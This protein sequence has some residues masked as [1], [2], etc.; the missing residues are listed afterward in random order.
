MDAFQI[1]LVVERQGEGF[2]ARW[3]TPDEPESRSF[4]LALPVDEKAA[5]ELR[6]YLEKYTEFVGAGDRKRAQDVT[7]LLDELG[8]ALFDAIF[9]DGDGRLVHRSLQEAL[10]DERPCLLTI[11]AG[12]PAILRQP[13]ELLRD[14]RGALALQGLVVRR[15]LTGV[16]LP[17]QFSFSLPLRVLLIVSRPEDAGFIDPRNSLPAVLDALDD[18]PPEQVQID[19]CE[20][21]TFARLEKLLAEARRQGRPYHILHFDG[22]GD[23]LPES[24]VG[25]LAFE[26]DDARLHLVSG[27]ELGDLLA[28]QRIPLA[29]LA[30]C[31]TADLAE[32]PVF[33]AVAPALLEAG[34]GS[35]VAFSHA[36]HI[37]ADRLLVERFYQELAAGRSAGAA[38]AEARLALR[39]D[40]ARPLHLG[41]NAATIDLQDWFIPQ[42]YQVG[43][44]PSFFDP[45]PQP[46]SQGERG[47]RLPSP[48]GR[49]A[50]GEGGLHFFPPPPLYKFHGRARE[51]LALERAFRRHT[52]VLLHAM[53]G[54]GK[55]ALSREAAAWWLRTGQ[56][57]AAVFT[58][59]EDRSGAE[60]AL[61]LLGQA[62]DG[63]DFSALPGDE[64]R[65]RALR[66]F[67]ERRVLW[68]WDNFE[69]VLP[70]W[71]DE[72]PAAQ[73]AAAAAAGGAAADAGAVPAA[74]A[75]LQALFAELQAGTPQGRLLVTCRPATGDLLPGI[76]R[77]ELGGLARP[78]SLALLAAADD[79][80]DLRLKSR[81]KQPG[82]GRDD[83]ERL[84]ELLDDHPLSLELVAPELQRSSPAEMC[85]EFGALV[86]RFR[87][88]GAFEARNRSLLASLEFSKRRLKPAAAAALPWLAWFEGGVFER[89][90][91]LFTEFDPAAWAQAR[92]ALEGVALLKV[93]D[94]GIE[95]GGRPYLRF[96]PTLPF[97]ARREQVP[98][99]PAAERRFVDVYVAVSQMIGQALRGAQPAAGMRLCEL[100]YANLRR[101]SRLAFAAGRRA[102]G[103]HIGNTLGSF[104]QSANRPRER[105]ELT[106]WLHSQAPAGA[107][108]DAAACAAIW[109]HAW[110]RFTQGQAQDA[111]EALGELL[112][113]LERDGLADGSDPAWQIAN[114]QGGLGRILLH[115]GRPDLALGPL[116]AAIA[117]RERLDDPGNLSV[118][119]G[120]L[121]NAL[122]TLGRLDEALRAAERG[123]ALDR[124]RGDQRSIAAGLGQTAEILAG[125][126]RFAQ[127]EARYQQALDAARQAGDR[128]LEGTFL[129]HLGILYSNTGRPE[130]AADLF[131]QA[132]RLFQAAGNL[133]GEM[134]ICNSL[135][136]VEQDLGRFEP[137]RAWYL[138]SR[139]LAGTLGDRR[140]LGGVAQNLGILYQ[141][142]AQAE[143]GAD[144]RRGRL[145]QALGSLQESLEVK[146]EMQDQPG[147][148]TSFYQLGVVYRLLGDLDAAEQ[149][150]LQSLKICEELGRPYLLTGLIRPLGI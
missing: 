141:A 60:R 98:D 59:F 118:T 50:G 97:A 33:S 120:D 41:P 133:V 122:R 36:L 25:V 73:D 139:E 9:P 102:E 39:A 47:G 3:V 128:E 109:E 89:F 101:A 132:L 85:A 55:T 52:A 27:R 148:S 144:A 99:P 29:L 68:V 105:A 91:L 149:N 150:A 2:S 4:P 45:H 79:L 94:V 7:R 62:L 124:E 49:G 58:S 80:N 143:S 77:L 92:A 71:A 15:M 24:G 19:F 112:G 86:E 20:P 145:E 51:L 138:R 6:W 46:L 146:L 61:A 123:L 76:K 129:Q 35:V 115:A 95:V 40:P 119:L 17:A 42:L 90:L 13:W 135:G 43:S 37:R 16:R 38:L 30:A 12:D 117:A 106:D 56:F 48:T 130:A 137:A 140:Q 81:E 22:H 100:E 108:L 74:L 8:R 63:D 57:E 88:Q 67:H 84:L 75:G 93:E 31:R 121:A 82:W 113:R 32:R 127:A 53:G 147:A 111:L 72:A 96:H 64:Q 87:N 104:L 18:L 70:Q 54:M 136:L 131:R 134:K 26:R 21:P 11:G 103:A 107:G 69:S 116:E 125:Q 1:R 23:Y 10:R 114:T 44:D 142:M 83:I 14:S 34:V 28:R 66:L 110:T 126:G 65:R 78:D 5:A